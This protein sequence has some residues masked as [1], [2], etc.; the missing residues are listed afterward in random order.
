MEASYVVAHGPKKFL[1]IAEDVLLLAAVI[2]AETTKTLWK[3]FV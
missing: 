3:N 2:V 1:T